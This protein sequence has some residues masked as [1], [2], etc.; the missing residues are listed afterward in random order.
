MA[1]LG[2][3]AAL[4]AGDTIFVGEQ[5]KGL[6]LAG[7]II[8]VLMSVISVMGIVI[9]YMYRQANK[10]YSYRLAERDTLNAALTA[11][12][13]TLKESVEETKEQ[14]ELIEE[15]AGLI[16]KQGTAFEHLTERLRMQY[17]ALK[18]DNTRLG[19]VISAVSDALRQAVAL[20][21][22]MRNT[23]N[24]IKQSLDRV[25]SGLP[26]IVTEVRSIVQNWNPTRGRRKSS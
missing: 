17:D 18:E 11:S 5:L 21:T 4:G 13:N 12:T 9:A 14:R 2:V 10:V 23:G 24:D 20:Q 1:M 3:V 7:A 22:E 25:V 6:G 26:T 8:I 15:L 16:A 19:M